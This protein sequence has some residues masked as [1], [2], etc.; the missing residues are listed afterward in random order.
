MDEIADIVGEHVTLKSYDPVGFITEQE[1]VYYA[2]KR[3][4]HAAVVSLE[5]RLGEVNSLF[6]GV[7]FREFHPCASRIRPVHDVV[8][9]YLP[10]EWVGDGRKSGGYN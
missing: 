7:K 2:D 5:E 10:P 6:C 1:I 3:V 4:N 8:D 9:V